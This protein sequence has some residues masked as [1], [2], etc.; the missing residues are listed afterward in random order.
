MRLKSW[1]INQRGNFD[2]L[3]K[4]PDFVGEE[5]LKC[6]PDVIVITEFYKVE[7]WQETFENRFHEYN[8]FVTDNAHNEIFLAIKKKYQIDSVF[9]WKSN[10]TE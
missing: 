6:D 2:N 10:Y 9:S 8:T 4:I 7:G 1:N 5:V 3:T